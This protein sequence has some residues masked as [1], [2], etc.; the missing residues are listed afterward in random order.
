[1]KDELK[2]LTSEQLEKLL[3]E[4][5]AEERLAAEKRRR[6]YEETRADFVRRMASETRRITDQ[7]R[8]FYDMIVAET[9]AFRRIMQEYGAMRRDDQQGFS[10]QDDDFRLE[11]RVNRIKR[12]DERA[13]AA[14]AR[15]IEFLKAWIKERDKGTDDPMYQ[16]AMTLL[17]RNRKGDLDYKS[18]SKLYELE[19][20]FG[21]R[22]YSEIMQLFKESNVVEGSA[23]NFYF[24]QR[25]ERGVWHKIEPSFNRM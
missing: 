11:V 4:K 25:D 7:V 5:R 22:E 1:M 13:D 24:Y 16:L 14:A 18:I 6:D 3:E 20:Q 9:D 12:F 17:E 2:N 8:M 23:M 15:L 19:G 10:V 21:D